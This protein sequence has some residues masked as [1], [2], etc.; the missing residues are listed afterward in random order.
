MQKNGQEICQA[1]P[2]PETMSCDQQETNE[3]E[4]LICEW[5]KIMVL[6][7]YMLI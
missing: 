1:N 6:L 4:H 3:K 5:D 7:L 2:T